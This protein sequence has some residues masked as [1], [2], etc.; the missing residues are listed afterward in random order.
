MVV[1]VWEAVVPFPSGPVIGNVVMKSVDITISLKTS[2]ASDVVQAVLA[3]L[4]WLTP[5]IRRDGR[6][7]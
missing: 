7:F 4:W 2:A 5:A 3:L 6:W 1:A